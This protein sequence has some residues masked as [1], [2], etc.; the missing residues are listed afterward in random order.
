MLQGRIKFMKEV[1]GRAL[2]LLLVV[3]FGRLC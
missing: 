3:V 1:G 2:A